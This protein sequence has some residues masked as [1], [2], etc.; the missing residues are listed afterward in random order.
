MGSGVPEMRLPGDRGF[1]FIGLQT[2]SVS[3]PAAAQ[4]RPPT[5]A[6]SH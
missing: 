6:H 1:P 3:E 2:P 4:G 5:A